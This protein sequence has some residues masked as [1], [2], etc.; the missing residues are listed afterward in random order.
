M[1]RIQDALIRLNNDKLRLMHLPER[2]G[3]IRARL[4]GAKQATGNV[5]MFLDS[6]VEVNDGWVEPLLHE[7][8]RDNRTIA[9][10]TIDVINADNFVYTASPMVRGGFNWGLH[11]RWD[12]FPVN[13]SF[14]QSLPIRLVI[15]KW[16]SKLALISLNFE[17]L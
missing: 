6:H 2:S 11:F 14:D 9:I 1:Q 13:R 17:L 8:H 15:N 7:L 12:S 10:P 16:L 3:L 4:Y 5:L